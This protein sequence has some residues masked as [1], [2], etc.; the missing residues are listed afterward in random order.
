M[1]T[2]N[3]LGGDNT[4]YDSFG[5]AIDSSGGNGSNEAYFGDLLFTIGRPGGLDTAD[6]VLNSIGFFFSADLTDGAK[7][8][9]QAWAIRTEGPPGGPPP[10]ADEPG[11][12][13]LAGAGLL[14]LAWLRRRRAP[15]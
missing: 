7:T 10:T 5:V 11:A 8:G 14:S 13:V 1:L 2:L 15:Q 3:E 4:P 12:L 6:F 9:A